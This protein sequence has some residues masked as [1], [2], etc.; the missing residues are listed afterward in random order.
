MCN[1]AKGSFFVILGVS[2]AELVPECDKELKHMTSLSKV[3]YSYVQAAQLSKHFIINQKR[4]PKRAR[5]EDGE[6]LD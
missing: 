4:V 6:D 2:R 5:V 3:F 1:L